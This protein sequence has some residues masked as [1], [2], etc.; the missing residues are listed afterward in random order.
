MTQWI[1]WVREYADELDPVASLRGMAETPEPRHEDLRPFLG[2]LS[3][4]GLT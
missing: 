3:P 4:Y 2:G 1:A